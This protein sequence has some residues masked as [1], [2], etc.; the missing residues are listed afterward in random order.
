MLYLLAPAETT[1][2]L[3]CD[4]VGIDFQECMLKW[5]PLTPAQY[6][7]FEEWAPWLETALNSSG[8]LKKTP[9]KLPKVGVGK[10]QHGAVRSCI[11]GTKQL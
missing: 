10:A 2:K 5:N 3:Y 6:K 9:S 8:F 11:V 7:Q 1:V 4:A